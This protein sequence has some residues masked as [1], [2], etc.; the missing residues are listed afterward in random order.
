M[1]KISCILNATIMAIF[2]YVFRLFLSLATLS[3]LL[4]STRAL[5][6]ARTAESAGSVVESAV[7]GPVFSG[8]S[9]VF[10]AVSWEI[11]GGWD[12]NC[13]GARAVGG[14]LGLMV[15]GSLV[16]IMI[17]KDLPLRIPIYLSKIAG[18]GKKCQKVAKIASN[19]L[20]IVALL[21][22]QAVLVACFSVVATLWSIDE[23]CSDSDAYLFFLGYFLLILSSLFALAAFFA[24]ATGGRPVGEGSLERPSDLSYLALLDNAGT[25]LAALSFSDMFKRSS[26]LCS[27]RWA[28]V[29]RRLGRLGRLMV[30][31]WDDQG[32]RA[33]RIQ[34]KAKKY[35]HSGRPAPHAD[36]IAYLG[37]SYAA[38]W[39]TIPGGALFQK[40]A[41]ECNGS[42]V[43]ELNRD[44]DLLIDEPRGTRIL[45]LAGGLASLL[46][47]A[48]LAVAPGVGGSVAVG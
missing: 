11:A 19:I 44:E 38:A 22:C 24:L 47:L 8:F 1:A 48:G 5:T 20:T 35:G 13:G 34:A 33:Y 2:S 29:G 10:Q 15:G 12:W 18:K 27:I 23:S 25:A 3:L 6:P 37:R 43:F 39:L 16:F 45:Q 41:E 7:P 9:A 36:V 21:A 26:C 14:V 4:G 46:G 30:G 32:M 40:L 42:V 28:E 17:G 31:G